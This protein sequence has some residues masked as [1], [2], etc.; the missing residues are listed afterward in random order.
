MKIFFILLYNLITLCK[1]YILINDNLNTTPFYI[2]PQLNKIIFYDF[3]KK[4][5]PI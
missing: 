5:K 4:F 2:Y 1:F 3:S